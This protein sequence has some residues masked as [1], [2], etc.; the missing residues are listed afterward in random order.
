MVCLNIFTWVKLEVCETCLNT[1]LYAFCYVTGFTMEI[2]IP[3][4]MQ[5]L[6]QHAH[7]TDLASCSVTPLSYH[8]IIEFWDAHSFITK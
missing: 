4:S 6:S 5:Y 2:P 1:L 3:K 8:L 7:K